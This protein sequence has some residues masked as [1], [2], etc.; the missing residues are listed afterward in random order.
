MVGL[1]EEGGSDA[2]F[3]R[4][5]S[6]PACQNRLPAAKHASGRVAAQPAVA[7]A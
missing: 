6:E 5:P 2:A 3:A 1:S 7:G 4:A